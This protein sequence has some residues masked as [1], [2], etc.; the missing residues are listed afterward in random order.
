LLSLTGVGGTGNTIQAMLQ[1]ARSPAVNV[2]ALYSL[3]SPNSPFQPVMTSAPGTW[4]IQPLPIAATPVI[5]L[6]GGSYE[7]A[8]VATVSDDTVGATI[9]YTLDGS[10]PTTGSMVYGGS[11]S[12]AQTSTL[13]VIA[14]KVGFLNSPAASAAYT[15]TPATH[16][17]GGLI[18]TIAGNGTPG[19]YGDS[20][21]AIYSMLSARAVATDTAGNVYV[22]DD[23][24]NVVR[25]IDT[26]GTINTIAGTPGSAGFAGDH[27]SSLSA[28][29]NGPTG[30][31]VDHAGNIYIA[32]Y[33]NQRIR[34]IQASG[35][36]VTIAGN[37][38]RCADITAGE[39]A[40]GRVA[41]GDQQHEYGG[42][43]QRLPHWD[44]P[45]RQRPWNGG[46]SRASRRR[47]LARERDEYPGRHAGKLR[48]H[49]VGGLLRAVSGGDPGGR[50][51]SHRHV[52]SGSGDC[53]ASI[54]QRSSAVWPGVPLVSVPA[55]P[56]Q[57]AVGLDAGR[58]VHRR[59]P[60]CADLD[61]RRPGGCDL[62]GEPSGLGV[63]VL[64]PGRSAFAPLRGSPAAACSRAS[65]SPSTELAT[66]G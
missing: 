28:K 52:R 38:T 57:S 7:G 61:R 43:G 48:G 59:R 54:E 63:E 1:I 36:I 9:F 22:A 24:T 41:G 27:L 26:A 20:N 15:I 30:I 23:Q 62:G 46:R 65:A 37:G 4:N 25:R 44:E 35:Q 50:G 47:N 40:A 13:K 17:T 16:F 31:A 32:D 53:A 51:C 8:Q 49:A 34:E 21:P 64:G 3:I 14:A 56:D 66:S 55:D 5:S 45:G 39:A 6:A 33:Q 58:P 11:I 10:T 18:T 60:G 12:I 19:D 2:A 42:A 29:L